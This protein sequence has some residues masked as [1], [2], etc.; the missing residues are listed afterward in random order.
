MKIA[1]LVIHIYLNFLSMIQIEMANYLFKTL[2]SFIE[3]HVFKIGKLQ[4]DKI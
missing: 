3:L 4:L 2:Y 1:Q